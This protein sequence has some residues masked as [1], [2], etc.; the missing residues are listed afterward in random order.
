[1]SPPVEALAAGRP[2]AAHGFSWRKRALVREFASRGDI[3]FVSRGREV[4]GA[5]TLLLWGSA[6]VPVGL[7]DD[8]TIV[9][10]EDGFVRS[11]GLGADLTRPLSWVMDG[12]GIYYDA[13][14]PSALENILA[15]EQW[16]AEQLRRAAALRRRLVDAGLTKYNIAARPWR[17]PASGQ[18]VVL[19]TGQVE[20]D[21]S[22]ATGTIDVR[23][24]IEL[25]RE[26]RKARP[27]AWVVYK[28]HPDVAA[29]LRAAGQGEGE[30]ARHCDEIAD[31][32]MNDLL[33]QV[34]EVHV[35]TS[36]AGFEALLR[37]RQV[38]CYGMPFYAG[39][40]L[41]D[42]RHANPR[43]TRR[44][45][46]DELVAGALVDYPVYLSRVTRRR[47]TP[48]QAIDEIVEWRQR[49]PDGIPTWRKW[50]RPWLARP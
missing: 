18:R 5:S 25:L 4:G 37:G 8:V 46:L 38:A 22:I 48:E 7:P 21:A 1:M 17:R 6:A 26:V 11:V 31:G 9:R 44:L 47:C 34:D 19:V 28:P 32:S 16:T 2:L 45:S 13:S 29:G 35:M 23:T 42:D 40:G 49:R 14:R 43:R 39:W 24:N 36:L 20:T 12:T 41:T 33:A 27:R 10:M 15:R 30:A 3:A 50:L